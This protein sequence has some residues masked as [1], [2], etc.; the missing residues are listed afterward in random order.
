MG[1]F[2]GF[3][4]NT[5]VRPLELLSKFFVSHFHHQGSFKENGFDITGETPTTKFAFPTERT[6]SKILVYIVRTHVHGGRKKRVD[7]LRLLFSWS[8][9]E[10]SFHIIRMETHAETITPLLTYFLHSLS[11]SNVAKFMQCPSKGGEKI[12]VFFRFC[13]GLWK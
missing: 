11:S 10:T 13:Q 7:P 8:N 5:V 12:N 9:G 1:N 2:L 6:D 3:G 4:F